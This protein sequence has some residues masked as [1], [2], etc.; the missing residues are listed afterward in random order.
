MKGVVWEQTRR[1]GDDNDTGFNGSTE[2]ARRGTVQAAR[3]RVRWSKRDE[4]ISSSSSC[5]SRK[6]GTFEGASIS[7]GSPSAERRAGA[8]SK[9]SAAQKTAT[10]DNSSLNFAARISATL[11]TQ[12][13][14][15]RGAFSYD[16]WEEILLRPYRPSSLRFSSNSALSISPLAKRSPRMSRAARSWP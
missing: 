1:K 2:E 8:E 4:R 16:G 7:Y 3:A 13:P 10:I 5:H 6:D 9:N 11:Q 15:R 12:A 14:P